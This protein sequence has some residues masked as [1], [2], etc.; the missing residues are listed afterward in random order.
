MLSHRSFFTKRN[1]FRKKTKN[2][3]N[4]HTKHKSTITVGSKQKIRMNMKYTSITE[5]HLFQKAYAKGKKYCGRYTAVYVLP[6]YTARRRM[7]ANPE[8]QFLNRIGIS[9]SKKLGGAV[10]RS[11]VRRIIREG[12]R[13]AE[14][15]QTM[16]KG[17]LIVI[18]ARSA[19]VREKSTA[20]GREL[21]RAFTSLG[22]YSSETQNTDKK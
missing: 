10:V 3:A 12:Y 8:K 13:S 5:N 16:K 7:L 22:M 18:G 6:D 2:K 21:I 20:I 19:A 17:Y 11:R 9:V 14:A 1:F 15:A 4:S